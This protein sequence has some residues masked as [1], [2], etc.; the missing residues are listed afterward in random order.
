[1]F[2]LLKKILRDK[3]GQGLSEYGLLLALIAVAC[4][5]V[6]TLMGGKISEK[7]QQVVDALQ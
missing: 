2:L 3:R 4:I 5:A 1:M 6:L 7:F